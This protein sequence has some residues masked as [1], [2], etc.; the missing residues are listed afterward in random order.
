MR[1]APKFLGPWER[2]DRLIDDRCEE[3]HAEIKRMVAE[4]MDEIP[5]PVFRSVPYDNTLYLLAQNAGMYCYD[6]AGLRALSDI[7]LMQRGLG[8]YQPG[9]QQTAHL[10]H[11]GFGNIFAL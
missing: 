5:A 1:Y 8:Q 6:Q 7:E 3:A 10:W 11:R 4:A 9:M 2:I